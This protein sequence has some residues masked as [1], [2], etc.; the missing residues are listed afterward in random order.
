MFRNALAKSPEIY[1]SKKK[2]DYI[3]SLVKKESDRRWNEETDS[4]E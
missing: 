3:S 1:N 4:K 2:E